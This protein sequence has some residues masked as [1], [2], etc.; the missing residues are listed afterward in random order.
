MYVLLDIEQTIWAHLEMFVEFNF[1]LKASNFIA[2]IIY[3]HTSF[4]GAPR[5]AFQQPV[6][7]KCKVRWSRVL[8]RPLQAV[9]N[10]FFC[11]RH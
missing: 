10:V 3:I 2:I 9:Y 8:A 4:S 11:L 7:N 6:Y 5:G 1:A